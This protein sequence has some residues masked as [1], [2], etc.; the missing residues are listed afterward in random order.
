MHLSV[1]SPAGQ[2]LYVFTI[3]AADVWRAGDVLQCR[4]AFQARG[5]GF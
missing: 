5:C 4:D 2:Y 1:A 3:A